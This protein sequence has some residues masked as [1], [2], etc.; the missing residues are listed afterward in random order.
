MWENVSSK[1][2]RRLV[3][4]R[5]VFPRQNMCVAQYISSLLPPTLAQVDTLTREG[6]KQDV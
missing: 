2:G 5:H 4:R 3:G 6:S 1:S